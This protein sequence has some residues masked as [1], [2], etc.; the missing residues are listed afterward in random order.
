[1]PQAE[2]RRQRRAF[3]RGL[4]AATTIATLVLTI[5]IALGLQAYRN[6]RW[7]AANED[8]AEE[9]LQKTRATIFKLRD[10]SELD[11]KVDAV[12]ENNI[13]VIKNPVNKAFA[14][15]FMRSDDG[16]SFNMIVL[17]ALRDAVQEFEGRSDVRSAVPRERRR[18]HPAGGNKPDNRRRRGE[19][20][21]TSGSSTPKARVVDTDERRLPARA[22]GVADLKRELKPLWP[23]HLLTEAEEERVTAAVTAIV[24]Y[25]RPR[26]ATDEARAGTSMYHRVVAI[27]HDDIAESAFTSVL[28]APRRWTGPGRRPEGVRPD[29]AALAKLRDDRLAEAVDESRRSVAAQRQARCLAAAHLLP[30]HRL[31]RGENR[32]ISKYDDELNIFIAH[33]ARHELC[34]GLDQRAAERI[35]DRWG[36]GAREPRIAARFRRGA[37][38][39]FPPGDQGPGEY[40]LWKSQRQAL[41]QILEPLEREAGI[42][43]TQGSGQRAG[44]RGRRCARAPGGAAGTRGFGRSG[45]LAARGSYANPGR[46]RH[47]RELARAGGH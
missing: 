28:D 2:Q 46:L 32:I 18:A 5:L 33:C 1:M 31:W 38:A 26:D 29:P 45:G 39:S 11:T 13:I 3:L 16:I 10:D 42:R 25:T 44:Q 22:G 8:A 27:L 4:A 17:D 41:E 6:W 7:A 19:R 43:R 40:D 36:R 20:R 14:R 24:G 37:C 30:F 9:I 35:K 23:P 47:S 34:Q 15:S 21:S 12:L